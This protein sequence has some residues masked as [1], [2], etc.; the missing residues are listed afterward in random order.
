MRKHLFKSVR[1]TALAG[2]ACLAAVAGRVYA[3]GEGAF[4]NTDIGAS[5]VTGLPS[6]AHVDPGVRFNLAPGYRIYNDDTMAV[7]LQFETGV[8]WN[9]VRDSF[10]GGFNQVQ[11]GPQVGLGEPPHTDLYQVPFMAGVEYSFHTGTLVEPYI[12]VAGGGVYTDWASY[13]GGDEGP[14]DGRLE[15]HQTSVS[16]AVQGAAGVRFKLN[17]HF[18]L[19]VG[20]KFL[21][22][23]P[24]D[25]DYLGT[26]SV[27]A[28]FTWRF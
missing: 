25:V 11:M 17:D 22:C 19:G 28:T 21:A 27:L 18:E 4:L 1:W 10:G 2:L 9:H 12:G 7:S 15:H 13:W 5:F 6:G 20:Y 3:D 14:G 8:I 24:N 26:H 16:G 23:F